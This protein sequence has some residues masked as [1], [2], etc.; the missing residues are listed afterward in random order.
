MR[1]RSRPGPVFDGRRR[2][3]AK[4][5]KESI[6]PSGGRH[7]PLLQNGMENIA[8]IRPGSGPPRR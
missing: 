6:E 3:C 2:L 5:R 1:H 8:K 7:L 4:R